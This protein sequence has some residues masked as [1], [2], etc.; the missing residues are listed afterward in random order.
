MLYHDTEIGH[1]GDQDRAVGSRLLHI[2]QLR[3]KVLITGIVG[4][5]RHQLQALRSQCRDKVVAATHAVLVRLVDHRNLLQARLVH[6][7]IR[8]DLPGQQIVLADADDPGVVQLRH[9]LGAAHGDVEDLVL[10]HEI[11][12]GEDDGAGMAPATCGYGESHQRA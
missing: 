11:G 3:S 9:F 10:H 8:Q 1:P 12:R 6:H 5:R 2:E 7:V 4:L